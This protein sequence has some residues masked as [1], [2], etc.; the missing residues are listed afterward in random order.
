MFELSLQ[1]I[2]MTTFP[3]E[4]LHADIH[5]IYGHSDINARAA[6]DEYQRRFP[7]TEYQIGQFS[8]TR[9]GILETLVHFSSRDVNNHYDA[10]SIWRA[11]YSKWM[12]A[13]QLLASEGYPIELVLAGCKCG[14]PFRTLVCTPFTCKLSRL[15]N[16]L[17]TLHVQFCSSFL[18]HQQIYTKILFTDEAM[19]NRGGNTNA[20]SSHVR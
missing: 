9:T 14:E 10:M 17:I 8:T 11:T 7:N 19:L 12:I 16:L 13:I 15:Y 1:P 3:N 4:V 6:V 20:Q 18:R 2:A 5:Y